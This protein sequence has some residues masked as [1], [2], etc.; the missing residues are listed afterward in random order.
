M[1][2]QQ[3]PQE[4]DLQLLQRFTDEQIAAEYTRRLSAQVDKLLRELEDTSPPPTAG[5]LPALV[6]AA[7][8]EGPG[9]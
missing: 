4:P 2:A 5:S 9:R 6:R 8:T 7:V 1:E 3:Q